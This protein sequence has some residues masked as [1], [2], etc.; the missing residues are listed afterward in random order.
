MDARPFGEGRVTA[1]LVFVRGL[2]SDERPHDIGIG[3]GRRTITASSGI[4]N[5]DAVEPGG[6]PSRFRLGRGAQF[7]RPCKERHFDHGAGRGSGFMAATVSTGSAW[8][9]GSSSETE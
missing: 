8:M 4:P 9:G 2:R 6:E 7:E 3:Q 5:A 1:R